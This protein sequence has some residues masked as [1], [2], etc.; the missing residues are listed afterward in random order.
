MDFAD[1]CVDRKIVAEHQVLKLS[2]EHP[3]YGKKWNN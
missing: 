2:S 1:Y 3:L